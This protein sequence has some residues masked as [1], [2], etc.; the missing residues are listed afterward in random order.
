MT[1][2]KRTQKFHTALVSQT[3]FGGETNGSVAKC[4]LF[5]QTA[6]ATKNVQLVLQQ[7]C[8]IGCRFFIARFSVKHE[9]LRICWSPTLHKIT[10]TTHLYA[11][12]IKGLLFAHFLIGSVI[13]SYLLTT[14]KSWHATV[15]KIFWNSKLMDLWHNYFFAWPFDNRQGH[16]TTIFGRIS[17]R[18]TI[19]DL[20]FSEHLL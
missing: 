6:V 15:S 17:V 16:P 12:S 11:R 18:K 14:L 13:G 1:S 3:S 5:S 19:L 8:K 2:E 7:C 20:E 10:A 4:Q 9:S